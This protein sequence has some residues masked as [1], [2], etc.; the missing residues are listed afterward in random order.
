MKKILFLS[1]IMLFGTFSNAWAEQGTHMHVAI[2]FIHD[3]A[4]STDFSKSIAGADIEAALKGKAELMTFVHSANIKDGDVQNIQNDTLRFNDKDEMEDFGVNC[5]LSM[6]A[7]T[8]WSVSGLCKIFLNG[9]DH[10]ESHI[11]KHV[12]LAK[13][14]TWYP[15]FVDKEHL[16]VAYVM[17]EIGQNL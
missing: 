1:I 15:I 2:F 10:T 11:I 3:N 7:D 13:E 17:K 6:K 12:A 14:I 8:G 5:S 4:L 9:K 16:V